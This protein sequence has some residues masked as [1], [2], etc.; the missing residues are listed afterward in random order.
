MQWRFLRPVLITLF[1]T[2]LNFS[3]T[4]PSAALLSSLGDYAQ[5]SGMATLLKSAG[6]LN[7]IMGKGKGPFTLLAP[8]NNALSTLGTATLENLLK[9]ENKEQ[10]IGILKKHVLPGK[11]KAEQIKAGGLKDVSGNELNMGSAHIT[12]SIQTK[13]GMIQVIDKVIK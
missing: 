8:T 3:C 10:L 12:E 2:L 13:G 7:N 5:L 4:S 6:G 11:F 1:I 9:P